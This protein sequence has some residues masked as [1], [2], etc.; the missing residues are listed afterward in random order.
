MALMTLCLGA[1]AQDPVH[2]VDGYYNW[3]PT[4]IKAT[5]NLGTGNGT[6]MKPWVPEWG[7]TED[8]KYTTMTLGA[9]NNKYNEEKGGFQHR[10]NFIMTEGAKGEGFMTITKKYPVVVIKASL[11]FNRDDK[12]VVPFK[13]DHYDLELMWNDPATGSKKGLPLNGLGGTWGNYEFGWYGGNMKDVYGRDSVQLCRGNNGFESIRTANTVHKNWADT[14]WHVSRITPSV[15]G[16]RADILIALNMASICS[17]ATAEGGVACLDTTSFS[18]AELKLTYWAWADT[19]YYETQMVDDPENPGTMKLDTV[20]IR[21]KTKEERPTAYLK[22]IKTFESMDAYLAALNDENNW[23]DGPEVA[24]E[25][26]VLNSALYD[27]KNFKETY[28][29]SDKA[30]I[31]NEAYDVALG[32][33]NNPEAE[34]ED[35]ARQIEALAAAKDEF[36][37]SISLENAPYINNIFTYNGMALGLSTTMVAVDS[38]VGYQVMSVGPENAVP[39]LFVD[40][41]KANGMQAYNLKTGKGTLVQ[42]KDGSLL[43]VDP[44]YLTGSNAATVVFGN[45]GSSEEPGYDFRIG[46][47]YYFVNSGTATLEVTDVVPNAEE[48]LGEIADFLFVPMEVEYDPNDHDNENYPMTSGENSGWEFNGEVVM[49]LAPAYKASFDLYEWDATDKAVATERATHAFVDGWRRTGPGTEMAIDKTQTDKDGNPISCLKLTSLETFDDIHADTLAT[50]IKTM[51]F[52]SEQGGNVHIK[53]AHGPYDSAANTEPGGKKGHIC[54]STYAINLNAGINRYF[55]I[56]WKSNQ[57]EAWLN[58]FVFFVRKR[59][60]EPQAQDG[61]VFERRGDVWVWD[62]FDLGVSFGDSKAC[63]QYLMWK[64]LRSSADAVWVDWIRF[65]DSLDAIPTEEI[66]TAIADVQKES[67]GLNVSVNGR[68]LSVFAEGEVSVYTVDARLAG[69]ALSSGTARFNLAEG[70]YVVKAGNAVK[71][72]VVK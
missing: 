32:V 57:P 15:Y 24:P 22:W 16:E 11:P 62:L 20:N 1:S 26:A 49:D 5:A 45:R 3:T 13:E 71:K 59:I 67:E 29:F 36:L 28:K 63:A 58:N 10:T 19:A 44:S 41:G 65:Y 23:G 25:K 18:L 39:F 51:D 9:Q 21:S 68:T 40:G 60:E 33:Y 2:G 27:A 43:I 37:A 70:V 64:G 47:F 46:D 8:M 69:Q 42:T 7:Y 50:L 66:V 54:D 55:A 12:E 56:K 4:Q 61:N 35:Y 30:D 38:Y 6:G 34:P 72:V 17:E 52:T 48:D 14:I 31:L 53:R